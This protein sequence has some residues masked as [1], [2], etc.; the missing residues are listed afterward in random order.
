MFGSKKWNFSLVSYSAILVTDNLTQEFFEEKKK[1]VNSQVPHSI[2]LVR[3]AWI[4]IRIRSFRYFD[5]LDEAVNQSQKL[6][7]YLS[8]TLP[9][10][11]YDFWHSEVSQYKRPL[12]HCELGDNCFS[13]ACK[14]APASSAMLFFL[15]AT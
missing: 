4:R 10:H 13:F 5:W 2:S 8:I 9:K 11:H 1:A 15:E 14:S 3:K 6:Q 12:T 7:T